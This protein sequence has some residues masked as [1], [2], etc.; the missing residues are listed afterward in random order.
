MSNYIRIIFLDLVL[1]VDSYS[2]QITLVK[3]LDFEQQRLHQFTLRA[4]DIDQ[5]YSETVCFNKFVR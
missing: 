1:S 4:S 3:P 5:L 2:G